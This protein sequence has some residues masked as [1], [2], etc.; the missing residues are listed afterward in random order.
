VIEN[1]IKATCKATTEKENKFCY[2][3]GGLKDSASSLL[4]EISKPLAQGLPTDRI[5]ERL[6]KMDDQ[7]CQLRYAGT[8][9]SDSGRSDS[10]SGR[11]Q[12]QTT[13][14]KIPI[15]K[16]VTNEELPAL[17][18]NQL[19]Q[20]LTELGGK[21]VGCMEKSEFIQKIKELRKSKK[22]EL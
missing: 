19:K 5:C 16:E 7:V 6:R 20:I 10:G 12:K 17:R 18:V 13:T 9:S 11:Q 3:V 2:Y 14:E 4:R 8:K 22:E 15:G 1:Q 21:C